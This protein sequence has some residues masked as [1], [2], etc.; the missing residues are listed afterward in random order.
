MTFSCLSAASL[1]VWYLSAPSQRRARVRSFLYSLGK[2]MRAIKMLALFE[3]RV[4]RLDDFGHAKV[5]DRFAEFEC[6]DV[7]FLLRRTKAASLV[8]IKGENDGLGEYRSLLWRRVE[9][10][11]L[12]RLLQGL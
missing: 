1:K 4:G 5:R 10:E 12:C 8:R 2:V 3:I 11:L 9:V 6:R 7:G